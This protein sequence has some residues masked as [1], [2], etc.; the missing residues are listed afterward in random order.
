MHRLSKQLI[1]LLL[2]VFVTAGMSLSVVQASNMNIKMMD[3][4]SSMGKSGGGSCNDCGGLGDSSG[5]AACAASGCVAPL[6]AHSPS[7]EAFDMA[8]VAIYHLPLDVALLGVGS[9]PDP[10][11]PRTSHIG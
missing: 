5:M 4:A 11:P 10:Y 7:V 9:S 6:M 8:S 1:V 3:M 2:A